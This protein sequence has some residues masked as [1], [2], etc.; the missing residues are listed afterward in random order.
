M[1][2][3]RKVKKLI[4]EKNKNNKESNKNAK[5]VKKRKKIMRKKIEYYL[6]KMNLFNIFIKIK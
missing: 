2:I 5:K 6:Y 3:L 1:I 4:N